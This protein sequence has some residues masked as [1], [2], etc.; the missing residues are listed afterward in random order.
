MAIGIANVYQY[1][2]HF[3]SVS[4]P[5][6][7][8]LTHFSTEAAPGPFGAPIDVVFDAMEASWATLT[9]LSLIADAEL[10]QVTARDWQ[11]GTGGWAE[12]ARREYAPGQFS[13]AGSVL[14]FQ[15]SAVITLK[16][17]EAVPGRRQ[18]AYNR[19]YMPYLNLNTM[20][21]GLLEPAARTN[22]LTFV[23]DLNTAISQALNTGLLVVS[24]ATA[25]GYGTLEARV[26]QV[27]DTQRRRRS[28]I[29]ENYSVVVF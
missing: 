22:F 20:T 16:T 5:Q 6:E 15:V 7:I 11:P 4:Q 12:V 10:T 17:Q 19:M 21:N 1:W 2:Y 23:Q 14:P 9:S 29:D 13:V 28:D 24:E 26:G 8:A 18:S 3:K 25:E 27:Y